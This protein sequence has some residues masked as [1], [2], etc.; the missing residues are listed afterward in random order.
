MNVMDNDFGFIISRHVSSAET[1]KYWQHSIRLLTR[2]YPRK[3]IVIIDDNSNPAFL[4]TVNPLPI[5]V[6]IINAS[7]QLKKS[8]ELLPYIYYLNN[9]HWF[10]NAVILHDSVFIN[11]RVQ[12]EKLVKLHINV[13]P[14][15]HFEPDKENIENTLRIARRLGQGRSL[16]SML[17]NENATI[18]LNHY[19]WTG[20][21]GVQ[22]FIN[23]KFLQHINNIFQFTNIIPAVKCRKDRCCLERIMGA[24]FS[25]YGGGG[26]PS[27]FGNIMTYCKWGI[28]FE[29][30]KNMKQVQRIV[31]VWTGR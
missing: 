16:I 28:T 9:L 3:K 22:S 25:R 8:G 24:I 5:Q 15:W 17:T 31:K 12:F 27:L 2:L 30:Y 23:G 14:L 11:S 7:D 18:Q 10:D 4:T 1:D 13:K 6:Q 19:K 20:C 21:F 26:S 29:E